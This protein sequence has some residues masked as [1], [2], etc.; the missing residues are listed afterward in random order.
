MRLV[1]A[2]GNKHKLSEITQLVPP[3]FTILDLQDIGCFEEIPETAPTIPEN[4]LQK[5]RYVFS[6]YACNC[7]ADD[8]GLEVN[9]LNG[10][11][12]VYSARYAGEEKSAEKNISKVL[13]ELAVSADRGARFRTV[14]AL[15]IN[16]K[17]LLFEGIVEG[18]ILT[19]RRGTAG[20]GYDP[21]FKPAGFTKSFAEMSAAEKNACSHRA[22][23]VNKLVDYLKTHIS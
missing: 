14:I 17:E 18:E 22:I 12:G 15:I 20:F 7:F 21:I 3:D 13:S 23:A 8:T 4:A 9:A 6:K 2:T 16:G 1:F 11:P 10:E 5:A 19:E